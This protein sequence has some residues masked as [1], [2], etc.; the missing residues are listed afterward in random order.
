MLTCPIYSVAELLPHSGEMV[1]LDS[2]EEYGQ[3]SLR[4]F[5]QVDKNHIFLQENQTIPAWI[6]IEIMAQG[7]AALEGCHAHNQNKPVRLGFLL[8]TRKLEL[9]VDEIPLGTQLQILNTISI[10]DSSGFAVC[11]SELTWIHAPA[12]V[13]YRLPE[14]RLLAKAALNVFSPPETQKYLTGR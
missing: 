9:F 6:A 10:R 5:A 8:G 2:I 4:A 12:Q 13:Q 14:N 7:V 11:D 3:E 1:L